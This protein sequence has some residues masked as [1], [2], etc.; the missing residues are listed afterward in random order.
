MNEKKNSILHQKSKSINNNLSLKDFVYNNSNLSN[1]QFNNYSDKNNFKLE[2]NKNKEIEITHNFSYNIDD[3]KQNILDIYYDKNSEFKNKIDTLNLQF[4]LETEKYLNYTKNSDIISSQKLQANLFIILFKQINIFIEEIE[5]LNKIIIENKYKKE[6]I[7]QRTNEINE[8]KQNILIK[9]N[10]IQSLKQSNDKTEK[11]LLEALLHEDKLIKDNE[12][13]RKENETYKSLTIVFENELKN[14]KKNDS[15]SPIEKNY[16]KH[17]KTYSDYGFPSIGEICMG[18]LGKCETINY[19][20]KSP[21]SDK[22]LISINYNRS[23]DLNN[24]YRKNLNNKNKLKNKVKKINSPKN[25][26]IKI[27]VCHQLLRNNTLR[28]NIK[29]S[30]NKPLLNPKHNTKKSQDKKEELLEIKNKAKKDFSSSTKYGTI[31]NSKIFMNKNRIIMNNNLGSNNSCNN[32]KPI[33]TEKNKKNKFFKNSNLKLNLNNINSSV[34]IIMTEVNNEKEKMKN[35]KKL[36]TQVGCINKRQRNMSDVSFIETGG[37][38][39]L[40]DDINNSINNN[41]INS[42]IINKAKKINIKMKDNYNIKINE[43]KSDKK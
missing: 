5:R 38:Q 16:I 40:N 1:L 15:S 24:K 11:K 12:R 34:N 39:K 42:Q 35:D 19:S 25:N 10:L 22:K 23:K 31:K 37:N 18:T 17:I 41:H 28:E 7:M 20:N 32:K 13:L 26:N 9:D 4:Y 3:M 6:K 33:N 21:L 36:K 2:E 29:I 30:L 27:N 43:K 8:K 14:N